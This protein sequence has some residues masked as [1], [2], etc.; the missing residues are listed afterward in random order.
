M[1]DPTLP[2]ELRGEHA[3][4]F[5][6]HIDAP[7]DRS[8]TADLSPAGIADL[9]DAIAREGLLQPIGVVKGPDRYRLIWGLRRLTAYRMHADRLGQEIQAM[10][11]PDDL[12]VEWAKVLEIDENARRQ[13]LTP[14]ERTA[15][16]IELAAEIKKIESQAEV[17]KSDLS[18]FTS[19]PA[20]D[21]KPK[22]G[23]GNKGIY[24][25]V[26]ERQKIDQAAVRKRERKV[27]ERIGEPV[28]LQKDSPAELTRKAAKFKTTAK[29]IKTPALRRQGRV[30]L[31]GREE[32]GGA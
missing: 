4:L 10:V 21:D 22:T 32:G 15:H 20:V 7:E 6:P 28:D 18:D 13:D 9:A 1:T 17:G 31:G 25:K 19:A 14:D 24:Q 11:Y 12:P 5:V 16:T 26:A 27:A 29:T 30:R 2:D 3:Y 8:R 23:R